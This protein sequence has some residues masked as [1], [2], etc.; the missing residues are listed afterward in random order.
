MNRSMCVTVMAAALLCGLVY[1]GCSQNE[2]PGRQAEAGA[3]DE[4]VTEKEAEDVNEHRSGKWSPGLSEEEKK[5]LFSIARDTLELSVKGNSRAFSF[6]NY[7]ITPKLKEKCATFVTFKNNGRLRGCIGCLEARESM[8]ESVHTSAQ[9][10]SN[11][12]K[13]P[14]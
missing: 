13:S 1:S 3:E 10:A 6:N 12:I 9:N 2:D 11:W 7:T 8:Y 5:T 4:N 14:K